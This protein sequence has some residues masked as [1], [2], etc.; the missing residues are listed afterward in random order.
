MKTLLDYAK[1]SCLYTV[2]ITLFL[3]AFTSMTGGSG[4]YITVD[5]F[6]L[7]LLFGVILAAST[8]L[9]HYKAWSPILCR[10]LHYGILT[11]A[12]VLIAVWTGKVDAKGASIIIAAVLFSLVY[13]LTSLIAWLIQ[14]KQ[15]T[16]QTKSKKTTP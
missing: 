8:P 15:P 13:A 3:C 11:A 6:L 4:A 16:N 12:F 7:V 9:L 5:Q 14:K 1:R 2:L 10:L